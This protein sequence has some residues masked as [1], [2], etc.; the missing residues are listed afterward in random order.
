MPRKVK[1]IPNYFTPE[2]AAALV[3]AAPSCPT[4]RAF[5][6]VLRTGLRVSE[7]L[8]LRRSELRLNHDPPLIIVRGESPGNEAKNEREVPTPA[9]LLESLADLASF[10]SKDRNKPMLDM[11]QQWAGQTMKKAAAQ[12]GMD[13]KRAHPPRLPPYLRAE[14]RPAR[15]AHPGPAEMAGAPVPGRHPAMCRTGRR[16]PLLGGQA[17]KVPVLSESGH[18]LNAI[19]LK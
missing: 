7:T 2:E 1:K 18:S 11:S 10:H 6:F 5:R 17:V 3:D 16:T 14:L 19:I 9:D 15:S 13:P 8:A 12:I 4:L